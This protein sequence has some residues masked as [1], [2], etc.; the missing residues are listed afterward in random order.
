MKYIPGAVIESFTHGQ[1]P[2]MDLQLSFPSFIDAERFVKISPQ[3][4]KQSFVIM[5]CWILK[6]LHC[7]PHPPQK[8]HTRVNSNNLNV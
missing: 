7:P 2:C 5:P 3:K 6:W 8:I 4:K 1:Q